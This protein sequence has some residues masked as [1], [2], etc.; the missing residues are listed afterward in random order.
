MQTLNTFNIFTSK[1]IFNFYKKYGFWQT[2]AIF[3]GIA[4]LSVTCII[5]PANLLLG[6][7]MMTGMIINVIV[8]TTF[9]PYH[10]YQILSLLI[11]LDT[12]RIN[13]YDK[14]I[15]D[16]LTKAYNRRYFFEVSKTLENTDSLIPSNTSLLLIDIDEFKALNDVYGHHIGDLALKMLTE[17]CTRLLRNTDIFARYGGD[18]FI[19]LLPETKHVQAYE[20][21]TRL[22]E[23]FK[24]NHFHEKDVDF[25]LQL[26]VGV[27]TATDHIKLNDLISLADK[28]LYK[29]KHQGKNQVETL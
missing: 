29:A 2:I 24:N 18:E 26:S 16:E 10:L 11:E 27:A 7:S 28:A 19:C 14:S 13:V 17:E 23:A 15:R 9:M 6:G 3:S 21:A 4:F 22:V 20:I 8:C 5:V 12:L 25:V 1:N